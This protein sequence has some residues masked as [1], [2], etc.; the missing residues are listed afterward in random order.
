MLQNN[1]ALQLAP[2]SD[3]MQIINCHELMM[4]S[5]IVVNRSNLRSIRHEDSFCLLI[6]KV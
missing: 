2:R 6:I 5:E 1:H 4:L 3:V